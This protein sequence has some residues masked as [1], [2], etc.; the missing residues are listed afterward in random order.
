MIP[1]MFLAEYYSCA[2]L[3]GIFSGLPAMGDHLVRKLGGEKAKQ[4]STPGPTN[5]RRL[6]QLIRDLR[7][8]RLLKLALNCV[9][10]ELRYGTKST[11]A[12]CDKIELSGATSAQSNGG[13]TLTDE[14]V[15][16]HWVYKKTVS[17]HTRYLYYWVSPS[18]GG[19]WQ[20][21]SDTDPS[22]K[23][24]YIPSP[25]GMLDCS[26]TKLV[27]TGKWLISRGNWA[28]RKTTLRA[29]YSSSG[30]PRTHAS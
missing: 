25:P 11:G 23:Y 20:V 22:K 27:G 29:S 4:L 8:P 3:L 10:F 7:S 5:I 1:I 18:L 9:T 13:Y 6:G 14:K 24:G 16:S 15:G 28:T 2:L 30:V 26:T 17:E 21:D 19:R 12:C